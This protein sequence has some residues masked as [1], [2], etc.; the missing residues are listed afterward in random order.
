M[1]LCARVACRLGGTLSVCPDMPRTART[2]TSPGG[3]EALAG[4]LRTY[5]PLSLHESASSFVGSFH[6]SLHGGV[7]EA[8]QGKASEWIA[9]RYMTRY[10]AGVE[11]RSTF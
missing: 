6:A 10:A 5:R 8:R 11:M 9:S 4:G 2:F 7:N 1:A 3:A